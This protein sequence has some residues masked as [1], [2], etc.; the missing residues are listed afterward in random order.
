M[1]DSH[2]LKPLIK[3][4]IARIWWK[5]RITFWLNL[6]F[7]DPGAVGSM[8]FQKVIIYN[9]IFYIGL[10]PLFLTKWK[11]VFSYFSTKL[12]NSIESTVLS[13]KII[14]YFLN[15][16]KTILFCR[17]FTSSIILNSTTWKYSAPSVS[18]P[19]L[20]IWVCC[21]YSIR[22]KIPLSFRSVWILKFLC[23]KL[24]KMVQHLSPWWWGWQ[25]SI[26]GESAFYLAGG[27]TPQPTHYNIYYTNH[28]G[29]SQVDQVTDDGHPSKISL[30]LYCKS[31]EYLVCIGLCIFTFIYFISGYQYFF[32]LVTLARLAFG[33][34]N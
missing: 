17:H 34:Y 33:V 16:S 1:L 26:T 28:Y 25:V 18:R 21:G 3:I 10:D 12:F 2:I 7:L 29:D 30:L 32:V 23:M 5:V 22:E 31:F 27:H 15:C 4:W 14:E 24:H 13:F 20:S 11:Y 6:I 19:T 8:H 9:K